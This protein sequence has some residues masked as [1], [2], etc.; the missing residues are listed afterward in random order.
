MSGKIEQCVKVHV[1][2]SGPG[3]GT[4]EERTSIHSVS[5]RLHDAI[6]LHEVGE[7]DGD[8]FG[9]GE[10]QLFMYGPDA[11]A[12]FE[13]IFPILSSWPA[14]KGGYAVKRFGPPG[15]RTEKVEFK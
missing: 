8:E 13:A 7:F 11:N 12:R 14:L 10:C 4:A 3:L 6:I 2:L 9:G 15:S 1:P 5:D